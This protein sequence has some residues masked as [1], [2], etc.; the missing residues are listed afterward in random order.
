MEKTKIKKYNNFV[1]SLEERAKELACLYAVEELIGNPH[2]A[3]DDIMHGIIEAL[4]PAAQYPEYS[5]VR[6]FVDGVLYS[7]DNYEK[8]TF[9]VRCKIIVQNDKRGFVELSYRPSFPFTG[10]EV[11]T[12]EE[13]KLVSTIAD[14]ISHYVLQ[15]NLKKLFQQYQM[16]I[17]EITESAKPE[18]TIV[19]DLLQKTDKSLYTIISRKMFNKLYCRGI[20]ETLDLFHHI[21]KNEDI[22]PDADMNSPQKKLAMDS[23]YSY[24]E[25]IFAIARK[26]MDNREIHLQ[27][28]KWINEEKSHYLVKVLA[29]SSTPLTEIADAIRRYH[30][31]NPAFEDMQSPTEHGVKVALIRRFLTDQLQFIDIA[32]NYIDIK[33]FYSLLQNMIYPAE[34]QGK[35]GGKSAGLFLAKKIFKKFGETNPELLTFKFP[36][37]WYITSDGLMHFMY[38]NNLEDVIEQKYKEMDDIRQ[39][40]PYIVQ[41]FK[42]AKIPTEIMY[43][44]S[45]ALDD[46]GDNPIIVRSSSLLEDRMGSAFAG[47]YKSLFLANQGSK[48][49]R[50][51][52]IMDAI[53][54]VYAST[55]G[56]DP[57][58]YRSERGLLD[59]NEEM[60]ILIQEVVGKKVG[61]Y[62]FPAFAGV[63]FSNN[64]FRWS[65]RIKREDGLIRM[66]PGL[67]TRAVDR[68]GNDFPV[69]IAPGQPNLRVNLTMPEIIGYAPKFMDVINLETNRFETISVDAIIQEVGNS[70]PMLNDIFSIVEDNNVKKPVGLGID[71]NRDR[72]VTTFENFISNSG[73]VQKINSALNVLKECMDMPI[74]IEFAGDGECLYL[75]QCRTQSSTGENVS[76][77]IPKDVA[78]ENIL[79]T[80]N[81]YISNGSV[82]DIAYIVYVDPDKY[83][84]K[85][86]LEDLVSIGA[87]VGK[88]NKLLPPKT[89]IL[90][91]PG[92]WGSR[93]DIRLGV[94]VTYSDIN[95]TAA[96][97]EIGKTTN[98]YAPDLSFGT[99]FFQDLVESNIRYL[100]LYPDELGNIFNHEYFKS[101]PNTLLRYLP[102]YGAIVDTLKVIN[103]RET[104]G[105]LIARLMFNADLEEA[106]GFLAA[107]DQQ[108][109]ASATGAMN[110]THNEPLLWR[111][112]M[113]D[114]IAHKIDKKRFGVINVYLHGTVLEKSAGPNSDIDLIFYFDGTEEQRRD[115]GIWLEGWNVCLSQINYNKSGFNIHQFLDVKILTPSDLQEHIYWREL[116]DVKSGKA[117]LLA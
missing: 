62:F 103:V 105:G 61:K 53:S 104:T 90:M 80:A 114:A 77:Q 56:P 106:I 73:Y 38:F 64:E 67:G 86:N 51:E 71:T 96:L 42:N 6:L 24:S 113:A 57:I 15:K 5:Q 34:S 78:E 87:A 27:I 1:K 35:L 7:S 11:F 66:V 89:F 97:I 36:K 98:G 40:Y 116:L 91:G 68:L 44:L 50:I 115:L 13:E 43:G 54:E 16:Q 22:D 112:R 52:A 26:Y 33:D 84:A 65:Q 14:R 109:P 23:I 47:K 83:A 37:T 41:A 32:K 20:K 63:A 45:R 101:S 75:L 102:E 69:L 46:F 60:G 99:H 31:I 17:K 74:D 28:Q 79:F 9:A 108:R 111:L 30:Q 95:N 81:K 92:R 49:Q 3:V 85:K 100:P 12:R 70:F 19:L 110:P 8:T 48:Q 59:Y 18:W 88:L 21:S 94:K 93:D 107:P 29:N 76:A 25:E 4:Q 10:S 72:I 39:E 58:G 55:F 2:L 82:P 117:K